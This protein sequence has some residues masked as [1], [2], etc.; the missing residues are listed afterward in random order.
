MKQV[1]VVVTNGDDIADY[2]I[3]INPFQTILLRKGVVGVDL[4]DY[5]I[6]RIMTTYGNI[7]V[8]EL[9]FIDTEQTGAAAVNRMID[10]IVKKFDEE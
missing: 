5:P 3:I 2:A 8:N 9:R 1:G 10:D 6:G 4:S 7:V